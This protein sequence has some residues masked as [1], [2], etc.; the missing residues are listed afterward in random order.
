MTS[1]Y[2][3]VLTLLIHR[4]AAQ[5]LQ[6]HRRCQSRR[7]LSRG[8]AALE[9]RRYDL[10]MKIVPVANEGTNLVRYPAFCG[11][12]EMIVWQMVTHSC[13]RYK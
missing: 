1:S 10:C 5:Y 12:A 7:L 9:A 6:T 3:S 4:D 13:R 11:G 8:F 2:M